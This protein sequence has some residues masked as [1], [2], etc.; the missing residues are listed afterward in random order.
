MASQKKILV[1]EDLPSWQDLL[2]RTLAR[3]GYEP[4]VAHSFS[5]AVVELKSA[6]YPLAIFDIRLVDR[7]EDNV[8]GMTILDRLETLGLGDAMEKVMISAYGTRE[9]M[10]EA[11]KDHDVADFI[12]K[13]RFDPDDFLSTIHKIFEKRVQANFDLGIVL[14]GGL[15]L[16]D[17]VAGLKLGDARLKRTDEVFKRACDELVSLLQRLF[18][19]ARSVVL[20]PV[21]PGRSGSGIVKAE[22]FHPEGRAESVI[23]KFGDYQEIDAEYKN[24]KEHVLGFIGGNRATNVLDLRRTALLGGIVYSFLGAPTQEMMDLAHFYERN[25]A[26]E[27]DD[28]LDNL[29]KVTCSNWYANKGNIVHFNITEEYESMLKLD[30]QNLQ[31]ALQDNFKS[32]LDQSMI[33]FAALPDKHFINPVQA[34]KGRSLS[35]ATYR[36]RTHGDLNGSNIMI[37][38]HRQTWLID[39]RRT[40]WGHIL[41]DCIELET[42]VKL[43]LL[44]SQD[45]VRRHALEAAL[46]SVSRFSELPQIDYQ[47]PDEDF[48][49]AFDVIRKLRQIA[50]D[51]MQPSDDFAEYHMGLLYLTLNNLRFYNLPKVSRLH[52]LLS[53]GLICEKLGLQA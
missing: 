6:Y 35:C 16:E 4:H 17:L 7:E 30:E 33:S 36:C 21:S 42:A 43:V 53:A 39:F 12:L 52:A 22:P 46:V 28:V 19:R 2:T 51:L 23:V 45:L 14:E 32:Y 44:K 48:A 15:T 11:F 49:K 26:P 1:V 5:E 50:K 29:F 24:Y 41:R 9:M 40:G 20:R 31:R 27:V 10:R 3:A 25:D 47:P 34:I 8:E 37:D 18:Y 38:P 13:D